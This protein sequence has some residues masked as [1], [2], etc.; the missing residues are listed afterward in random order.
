MKLALIAFVAII[1]LVAVLSL[2]L[3][4]GDGGFR[5]MVTITGVYSICRPDGYDAVCFVDADGKDGGLFCMPLSQL[6]NECKR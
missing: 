3:S 2:S 1:S 5:R 6:G 4:I